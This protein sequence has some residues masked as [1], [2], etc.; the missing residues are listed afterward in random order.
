MQR[1]RLYAVVIVV[2][3]LLA[4]FAVV[5]R[6]LAGGQ[7]DR[8]A[9]AG[10]RPAWASSAAYAGPVAAGTVLATRVY[11]AGRDPAGLAAYAAAVSD[12]RSRDYRRYLTRAQVRQ[13]YGLT[14]A[15]VGAVSRWLAGAGL[16][17]TRV[18]AHY[19]AIRGTAAALGSA[20]GAQ[21]GSYRTPWGVLRAPRSAVSV[22]ASVASAV[23][24]VTG[25][26][27]GGGLLAQDGTTASL[28]YGQAGADAAPRA[29]APVNEGACSRYWG[30]VPAASLPPAYGRTLSYS[31]CG[32]VP[33]QLRT[34]YQVSGSGLTGAGVRIAVVNPG[35]SPTIA[36]DVDTYARAHGG[37]PLRPGQLTQYL[38]AGISH[39]CAAMAAQPDG[40]GEEASDVEAA[41]AMAPDASLAVVGADCGHDPVDLL[42]AETR[43][44]DGHLADIV[45]NSW[46]LSIEPLLTTGVIT[47]Y[48]QVF[49]QGAAEGIGFYFSSGDRGDWSRFSPGGRPALEYPASDPW[50]TSVGGTSLAT[51]PGGTYQ[52]ETG[53]GSLVAPLS[54]DG[55][56]WAGL[57]GRFRGGAGGGASTPF[58]QPAY[59]RGIVPSSLSE[60]AGATAAMRVMP[61]IAADADPNTGMLYGITTSLSPGAAPQYAEFTDAGTSLAA[62][63]IAGIQAD[64]Q[65]AQHGVPIGFANPAIYARYGTPA[66]HDVTDQPFGPGHAIAAAA[67]ERDPATGAITGKAYT[68]GHDTSLHATTGYDDVTGVGTPAGAYLASY[69]PRQSSAGPRGVSSAQPP[70]PPRGLV[71]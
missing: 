10:S 7:P 1:K 49:E 60:P 50:V 31:L 13:R 56:S 48:E 5:Q 27:T 23:L 51:G 63:L 52:W 19:V 39:S 8:R 59:Q 58:T 43:I 32:Y 26:A 21:L 64:A 47:A 18:T 61:D 2:V 46:D 36:A 45:S 28:G 44:V 41:H 33:G 67:A 12:P 17:V 57:P 70:A 15:Q 68:F 38:P 66:Y 40:Y 14:A 69:R 55:H 30:Q 20:F 65:Q 6:V 62:P 3:T 16:R 53:W 9:L 29:A 71:N 54:P 37:Q 4:G 22:P 25:L 35:A 34:A 11:L 24:G 42:D